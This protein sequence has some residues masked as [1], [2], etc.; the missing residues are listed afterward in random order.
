M[1]STLVVHLYSVVVDSALHMAWL[2]LGLGGVYGFSVL[3][4]GL[5]L[6]TTVSCLIRLWSHCSRDIVSAMDNRNKPGYLCVAVGQGDWVPGGFV[7]VLVLAWQRC[8]ALQ[9]CQLQWPSGARSSE[10]VIK[11][12]GL[13]VDRSTPLYWQPFSNTLVLGAPSPR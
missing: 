5:S 10:V 3:C 9:C 1:C 8:H 13:A 6:S 12:T 7:N 4:R 2:E 11:W